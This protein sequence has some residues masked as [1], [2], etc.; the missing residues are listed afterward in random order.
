MKLPDTCP[1]QLMLSRDWELR[2]RYSQV[3]ADPLLSLDMQEKTNHCGLHRRVKKT[4]WDPVRFLLNFRCQ[5]RQTKYVSNSSSCIIISNLGR[6]RG[7][8]TY[9]APS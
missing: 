5:H 2:S 3:G 6:G 8:P 4:D 1:R 9:P 7:Q